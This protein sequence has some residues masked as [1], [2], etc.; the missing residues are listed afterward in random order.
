MKWVLPQVPD[1]QVS[2][3]EFGHC[4]RQPYC[5]CFPQ[6]FLSIGYW[7]ETSLIEKIIVGNEKPQQTVYRQ[8]VC[9][10]QVL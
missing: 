10:V 3:L 8:T 2:L 6:F 4:A 1:F 5:S 7:G 9:L